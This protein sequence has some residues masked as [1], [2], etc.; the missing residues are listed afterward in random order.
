MQ[1]FIRF[2]TFINIMFKYIANVL[3]HY[4][5][6]VIRQLGDLHYVQYHVSWVKNTKDHSARTTQHLFYIW[7]W[8][9]ENKENVYF[10]FII[11][12]NFNLNH[13]I[14]HIHL[15]HLVLCYNFQSH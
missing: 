9:Y 5:S 12:V 7:R 1:K 3:K 8:K 15:N 6:Y 10:H 11:G 4:M 13:V 2:G 14:Y